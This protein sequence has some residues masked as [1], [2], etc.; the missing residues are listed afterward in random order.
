MYHPVEWTPERIERFWNF[1]SRNAGAQENYFSKQFGSAIVHLV[2]RRVN[3]A[4]I[5]VD[6]GCGPGYFLDELLRAGLA[7]KAVDF[8]AEAVDQVRRRFAGHPGFLGGMVGSLDHLP[9]ENGVASAVFLIEVLEHLAPELAATALE[10]IQRVLQPGGSL[11]ITV[12]NE[13]D[14]DESAVACPDC[15]CVFHRMQHLQSFTRPSLEETLRK[16]GF[17]V[18]WAASLHLKHFAGSWATRPVGHLQHLVHNLRHRP[19]PHLLVI[20]RRRPA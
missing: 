9:L 15:G 2:R 6:L 8:S 7:C 17:D 14:L 16:A 13:E 5:L 18:V 20:G 1:Y 12:P 4:G 3:L 11:I 19:N 10:E